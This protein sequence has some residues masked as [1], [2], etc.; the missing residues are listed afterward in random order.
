MSGNSKEAT[1]ISNLAFIYSYIVHLPKESKK[2]AE[3]DIWNITK[4]N[5]LSLY[6]SSST[7]AKNGVLLL[8]HTKCRSQFSNFNDSTPKN[9]SAAALLQRVFVT[10]GSEE[11]CGR[12]GK[13]E[14]RE[15][16]SKLTS[17]M[18]VTFDPT[19]R[20]THHVCSIRHQ[21]ATKAIF[22]LVVQLSWQFYW[23]AQQRNELKFRG[24]G[25]WGRGVKG[26]AP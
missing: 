18:P 22:Q 15:F 19:W 12:G 13:G 10:K 1:P 5:I 26:V 25:G 2:K 8:L 16:D 24:K 23:G 14:K 21:R 9:G 11:E 6:P 20:S 17:N 4:K 7:R 3:I